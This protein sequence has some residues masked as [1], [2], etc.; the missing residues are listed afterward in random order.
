MN[1]ASWNRNN[2]L[3]R[4]DFVIIPTHREWPPLTAQAPPGRG[5]FNLA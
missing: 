2:Q 5:R 1:L 3:D 4:K